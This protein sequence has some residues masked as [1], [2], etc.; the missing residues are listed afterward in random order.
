MAFA[1]MAEVDNSRVLGQFAH[2]DTGVWFEYSS[3]E[4]DERVFGPEYNRKVWVGG[5]LEGYYRLAQ[6][7]NT[8]AYVVVDEDD[9]GP[10]L[11]KWLLK[12]H[13]IYEGNRI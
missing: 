6:V 13:K 3:S 11:D 5:E 7:K 4:E 8:V 9:E 10:V 12:N 1:P 2:K